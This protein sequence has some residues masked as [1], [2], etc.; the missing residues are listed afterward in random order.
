MTPQ[1]ATERL[2]AYT[3]K[4]LEGGNIQELVRQMCNDLGEHQ[5]VNCPACSNVTIYIQGI[6][7][8]VRERCAM[9]AEDTSGAQFYNKRT[10]KVY[11]ECDCATYIADRIR[12][13]RKP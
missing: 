12:E 10:G 3:K 6:K 13:S 7:E 4:L 8:F 9:V 5:A 2:L 1:N 11:L